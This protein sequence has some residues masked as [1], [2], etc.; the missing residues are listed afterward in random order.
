MAAPCLEKKGLAPLSLVGKWPKTPRGGPGRIAPVAC[1]Y[2]GC[3]GQ[4]QNPTRP[5]SKPP[6]RSAEGVKTEKKEGQGQGMVKSDG[7][8]SVGERGR[9]VRGME[10]SGKAG[11]EQLAM[12]RKKSGG[13]GRRS[14]EGAAARWTGTPGRRD[15][16]AEIAGIN[17]RDKAC[18]GSPAVCLT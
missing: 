10:A 14:G 11:S 8:V 16:G 18:E 17:G 9:K 7:Q 2:I 6:E 5:G 3:Q 1:P 13:C 4:N 12:A 15:A